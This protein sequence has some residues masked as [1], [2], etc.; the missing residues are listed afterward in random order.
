MSEAEQHR[1]ADKAPVVYGD[2]PR[3][4][5][6]DHKTPHGLCGLCGAPLNSTPKRTVS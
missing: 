6:A 4:H 2:C 5:N 3:C 1:C